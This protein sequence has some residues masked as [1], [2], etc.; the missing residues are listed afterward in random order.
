MSAGGIVQPLGFIVFFSGYLLYVY[1][2]RGGKDTCRNIASNMNHQFFSLKFQV[3]Y[4]FRKYCHMVFAPDLAT[5]TGQ[6]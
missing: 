6:S 4:S 2:L 3:L 1:N 5:S